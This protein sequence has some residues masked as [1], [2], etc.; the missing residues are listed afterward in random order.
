LRERIGKGPCRSDAP[1]VKVEKDAHG[2]P[3]KPIHWSNLVCI[4]MAIE[5]RQR[6]VGVTLEPQ[7]P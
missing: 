2:L 6:T 7:P 3:M 1:C 5:Q 4:E